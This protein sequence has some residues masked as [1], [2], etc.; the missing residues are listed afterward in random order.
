MLQRMPDEDPPPGYA[1]K[2]FAI[3]IGICVLCFLVGKGLGLGAYG[4]PPPPP[5]VE[6][7][8]NCPPG[9]AVC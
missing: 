6:F 3:W 7:G 4:D 5:G 9:P 2:M 1:L 8:A